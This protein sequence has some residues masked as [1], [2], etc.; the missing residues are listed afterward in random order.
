MDESNVEQFS[1]RRDLLPREEDHEVWNRRGPTFRNGAS[2]E[3]EREKR[4]GRQGRGETSEMSVGVRED[5]ARR[6]PKQAATAS[7]IKYRKF[8]NFGTLIVEVAIATC[9]DLVRRTSDADSDLTQWSTEK[10]WLV[11]RREEAQI[12]IGLESSPPE[13]EERKIVSKQFW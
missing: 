2:A 5:F 4:S 13:R 1:L 10:W 8:V 12:D 9:D 6:R 3:G 7:K 11:R